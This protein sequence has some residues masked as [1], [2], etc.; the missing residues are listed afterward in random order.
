MGYH[1]F[2][3]LV[4]NEIYFT[5]LSSYRYLVGVVVL[6]YLGLN[7]RCERHWYCVIGSKIIITF[8]V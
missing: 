7:S 6:D 1:Y 3:F 8:F 5:P 2:T 4:F